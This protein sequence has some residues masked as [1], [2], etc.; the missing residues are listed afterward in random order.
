MVHI[1][2][3]L[4]KKVNDAG[5]TAHPCAHTHKLT[6]VGTW[7]L[8][9][10]EVKVDHVAA[11]S[12]PLTSNSL[13]PHGLQHARPPCPS[14]LPEVC[15]SSCPLNLWCHPTISSSVTVFSFCLQSSPTSRSFPM[16][17]LFA[18]GAQN[19]GAAASASILP[20]SIQGW[21]PLRLTGLISLLS[22]DSQ[23]S[24]PA[25]SSKTLILWCSAFF[26]LQLSYPY[27]TTGKTITLTIWI[28]V[29]KVLTHCLGLS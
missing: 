8:S 5:T 12:H 4:F 23:Q 16:S 10:N 13:R 28:F 27:M 24:F 21:F 7:E 20:K 2:K 29:G 22:K 3:N 26:I 1:R 25:H 14:P 19:I 15:P 18:S 17:Q 11:L 9:Q 6:Q